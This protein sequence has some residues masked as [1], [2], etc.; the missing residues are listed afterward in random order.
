[1]EFL[2]GFFER[3]VLAIAGFALVA[4]AFAILGLTRLGFNDVPR[5]IFASDDLVFE[6]LLALYEEFGSDDNDV[7]VVLECDDWFRSGPAS[8][9]QRLTSELEALD[10][11]ESAF[12]LASVLDF[13][14][15]LIPQSLLPIG[16]A[17]P[18]RFLRARE[19][20]LRHP[21]VPGRLLS[22]DG[23]TALCIVR[24]AGG[25]LGIEQ[26]LPSM[27]S[28]RKTIDVT[29]AEY[30]GLRVR[31]TG[32]PVIRVDIYRSIQ[33]EQRLF[34]A[35]GASVCALLGWF[36]FRSLRAVIAVT[37]PPACGALWALGSIGLL[38]QELD[39]L[40][41]VLPTLV[42]V[43]G[44]TDCVHLMIDARI[45][46]GEGRSRLQAAADAIR[47]VGLPCALT[48][49]TTAIG[50]GSLAFS[51]IPTI[52]AFGEFAALSVVIAF[53]AVITI[54]PLMV[55]L[56][57]D[58]GATKAEDR[59]DRESD[60]RAGALI[61]FVLA[62][63]R[64][65]SLIGLGCTLVMLLLG[66]Q[67]RPENRLTESL[68]RGEAYWALQ[69][70]QDVFGGILP[71]YVVCEWEEG[72]ELS[73]PQVLGALGKVEDLLEAQDVGRPT[74]ILTL[75]RSVPGGMESPLET[76]RRLPT[77]ITRGFLRA[78]LRKSL[79]AA[80]VPDEGTERMAPLFGDIQEGLLAIQKMHG[81]I[82][83]YLSGTDY[84]ARSNINRMITG[85][86][87][88]LGVAALLIFLVIALE[89]R[90]WFLGLVSLV[91]NLFP[92]VVVAGVLAVSGMPLQ[93]GSAV[94]F[95]V[96]LGLAVD[97]TIHFLSRLRRELARG[98]DPHEALRSSFLTVGKAICITTV[99]L[100][101]GFGVVAFSEVPTNRLF[102]ALIGVGL[103]AALLGDL[104]LLPALVAWLGR[105]QPR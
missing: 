65:V 100:I 37:I 68:P 70:C 64:S 30:E 51:D 17:S 55:W 10:S 52:R 67:L 84:V 89:Y 56:V 63:A 34:T 72:L 74:S 77:S 33:R 57:G 88:S 26:V 43:I 91:P 2:A 53:L 102:A 80:P 90:S 83:L 15:G 7:L 14:S 45:S 38:G 76:L 60:G 61:D 69:H 29:L 85:L 6:R 36:L 78:D 93:M 103:F 98:L 18:E 41:S 23:R 95:S 11:V 62:H 40:G 75:L 94:L 58:V 27:E 99:I 20:S 12:S 3:R 21:L 105:R 5:E 54:M 104:V 86:S 13:S 8:A 39:I 1:M 50:F 49:V 19:R 31:M 82:T 47:H 16:N 42:I 66:A 101:A 46:L 92:L 28:I 32:V 4:T 96:L 48:S 81:G 22:E 87:K 9:L 79:V 59:S 35:V 25:A 71:A 97:D 73:S 24:L 44:F